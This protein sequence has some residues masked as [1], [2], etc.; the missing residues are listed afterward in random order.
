MAWLGLAFECFAEV[1][2]GFNVLANDNR[3]GFLE[4]FERLGIFVFVDCFFLL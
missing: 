1:I 3:Y 2:I 4:F